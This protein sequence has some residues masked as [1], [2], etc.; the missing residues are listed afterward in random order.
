LCTK[1]RQLY[2]RKL[3]KCQC[4]NCGYDRKDSKHR[5]FKSIA[6]NNEIEIGLDSLKKGV[7]FFIVTTQEN[8]KFQKTIIIK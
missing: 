5:D 6:N 4:E 1:P 3:R 8:D 7:Y 2:C